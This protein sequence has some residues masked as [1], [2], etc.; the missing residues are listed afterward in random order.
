[1]VSIFCQFFMGVFVQC[2]MYTRV[3]SLLTSLAHQAI[4]RMI[5][6]GRIK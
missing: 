4:A 1:M 6:H 5:Q 2:Q 3:D